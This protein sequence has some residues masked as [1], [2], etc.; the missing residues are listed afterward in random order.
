MRIKERG[1]F[2]SVCNIRIDEEWIE[3]QIRDFDLS[4]QEQTVCKN[5]FKDFDLNQA[6]HQ[7]IW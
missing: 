4:G 5:C 7:F 6:I 1:Q 2:C 3:K